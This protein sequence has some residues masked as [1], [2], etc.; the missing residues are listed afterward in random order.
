MHAKRPVKLRGEGA[1]PHTGGIRLDGF[2][3]QPI[4]DAMRIWGEAYRSLP[5]AP[6]RRALPGAAALLALDREDILGDFL[7][8]VL[9]QL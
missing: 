3:L 1:G 5:V 6:V 8:V 4:G 9:R 7:L 2:G